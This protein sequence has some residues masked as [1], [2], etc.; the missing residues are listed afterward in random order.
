MAEISITAIGERQFDVQVI[1]T[2]RHVVTVPAALLED[3][4]LAAADSEAVVRE[5]F[6]F[7][8]ERE[9]AQEILDEFSLDDISRY[10]PQY[11][12]KLRRTL[13]G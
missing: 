8:L 5:S 12:E 11:R 1:I 2:T 3:L 4:G 6:R 9:P 7:L 10:Y 13:G